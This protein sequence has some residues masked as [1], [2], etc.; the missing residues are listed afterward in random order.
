MT[1]R[2]WDSGVSTAWAWPVVPVIRAPAVTRAATRPVNRR[3]SLPEA[4]C[5]RAREG[6][7]GTGDRSGDRRVKDLMASNR[8]GEGAGKVR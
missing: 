2:P 5:E 8:V 3:R 1:G 7:R 6:G 4:E